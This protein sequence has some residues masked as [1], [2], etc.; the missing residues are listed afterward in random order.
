M[1]RP[2]RRHPPGR[3]AGSGT[4]APRKGPAMADELL[5]SGISKQYSGV[6]AVADVSFAV[7]PGEVHGLVG[8]NGAGK[9]TAL[10]ILTGSIPPDAG[11]SPTGAAS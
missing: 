4:R 10:G 6:R 11:T 5:V 9:S 8:P 1:N 2:R 7:R 3:P